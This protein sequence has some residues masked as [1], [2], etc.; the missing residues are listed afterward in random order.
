MTDSVLVPVR[1]ADGALVVSCP[2]TRSAGL[3]YAKAPGRSG[4]VVAAT[5]PGGVIAAVSE[6]RWRLNEDWLTDWVL[7]RP[8]P[9]GTPYQGMCRLLPGQSL[10]MPASGPPQ[11]RT[12]VGPD[13]W[14]EPDL[15]GAD[16]ERAYLEVFQRAVGVLADGVTV[17]TSE[18]SGG[19][20]STFMVAMLARQASS[21]LPVQAFIWIP[22][23]AAVLPVSKMV[24]SDEPEAR[25]LAAMYPGNIDLHTVVTTAERTPLEMARRVSERS[26]WPCLGPGNMAWVDEIRRL[27][28]DL[29]SPFVW[30]GSHGNASFSFHHGYSGRSLRSRASRRWRNSGRRRLATVGFVTEP[31]RTTG[32]MDRQDYLWWLAGHRNPHAGLDNPA[33]FAV[34]SVDP[35]RAQEVLEVAARIK[36][37][38]WQRPGMTRGLARALGAGIVPDAVRLRTARG[39]QG[40]DVWQWIYQQHRVYEDQV[41]LLADTRLLAGLVDVAKVRATVARWPWGSPVPPPLLEVAV[42]NRLLAFARFIRDTQARLASLPVV[43]GGG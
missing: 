19:L 41:D 14:P 8:D 37:Q 11:V 3:F 24:A 34:P 33:A 42:V 15:A 7:G 6:R 10:V 26:W 17:L 9:T 31:Q 25:L 36:P 38:A 2:T 32:P 30:T 1:G 13:V 18:V 21:G 4:Q 23:S 12:W 22:A 35:F 40:N 28:A 39:A 16:A 20:D 5:D 29:G 27:A 43:P